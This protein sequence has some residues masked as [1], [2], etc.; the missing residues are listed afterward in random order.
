MKFIGFY[1]EMEETNP[2]AT[3][4]PSPGRTQ[5]YRHIQLLVSTRWAYN[6]RCHRMT[7]NVI[8]SAFRAQ[9]GSSVLTDGA[10]AWRLDLASYVEHYAIPLPHDFLDFARHWPRFRGRKSHVIWSAARW[11]WS[12]HATRLGSSVKCRADPA[13][14][15]IPQR[16]GGVLRHARGEST[17]FRDRPG[18]GGFQAP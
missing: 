13:R 5:T 8:G 18:Q 14:S 6:F 2:R 17:V 7:V 3:R 12:S 10:F 11:L 1:R 15:Q 9:E 16:L 4:P